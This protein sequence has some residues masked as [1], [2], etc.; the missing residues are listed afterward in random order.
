MTD[1]V[2]VIYSGGMDSFTLLHRARARGL[3]VHALS[4]NYGQ[5][6][7]RELDVASSVCAAL[8][9][10]HKVIDIRAMSE[11]MS[12]SALTS[13]DDIPEGGMKKKV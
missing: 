13:G 6:H 4:F 9:I 7:V 8:D 10:P 3:H 2:V 11:V 1:T 5:R 12:G